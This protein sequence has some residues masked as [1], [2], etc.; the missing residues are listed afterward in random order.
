ML[1]TKKDIEAVLAIPPTPGKKVL[2]W[3]EDLRGKAPFNILEDLDVVCEPEVHEHETDAWE[4]L[5]GSVT[6]VV[7]GELVNPRKVEGKEGEWKGDA[8]LGGE[9]MILGVGDSLDI[10]AGVPHQHIHDSKIHGPAVRMKIRKI[11]AERNN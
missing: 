7:G 9:E 6:F 11:P 5:E 1:V 2:P 3:P 8:I 4:V 10:P